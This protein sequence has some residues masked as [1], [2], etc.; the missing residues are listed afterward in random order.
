MIGGR[1]NGVSA[2]GGYN[3][4]GSNGRF[5]VQIGAFNKLGHDNPDG[6]VV[7]V[8]LYNR[9]A[10]QSIPLLNIR[11]L[12]KLLERPLRPC[13]ATRPTGAD[14]VVQQRVGCSAEKSLYERPALD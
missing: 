2:A 12:S 5:A 10:E 1:L 11:G 9:A 13:A 4:A 3:Y 8:G 14:D 6:T 7:Q